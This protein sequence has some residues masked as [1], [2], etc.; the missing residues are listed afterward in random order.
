MAGMKKIGKAVGGL[1][2]KNNSSKQEFSQ[3]DLISPLLVPTE[4]PSVLMTTNSAEVDQE[5]YRSIEA[6]LQKSTPAEFA[7]FF[8]QLSVFNEKFPN[9]DEPTRYQLAFHAAQTA[10]KPRN[11]QLTFSSLNHAVSSMMSILDNENRA[12]QT[13]N[14]QGFNTNLKSVQNKVAEIATGIRNIETRLEAVQKELDAF[15]SAKNQEKKKLDDERSRLISERIVVEGEINKL[16]DKK[17]ERQNRF[18]VAL[19]AQRQRLE[20]IKTALEN[21]LKGIH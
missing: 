8:N 2:W 4:T 21:N 5:F 16:Q 18:T 19:Q 14:E 20:S 6:E 11:Q 7:E 13:Q 10:L 12:F 9:L 1:F 15:L 17:S 3:P